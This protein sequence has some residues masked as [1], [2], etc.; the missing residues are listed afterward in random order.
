MVT[1]VGDGVALV[2]ALVAPVGG[3]DADGVEHVGAFVAPV[4][5][6]D[7]TFGE[8]VAPVGDAVAE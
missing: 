7:A 1:G 2:G 8:I 4:G 3:F 5:G 6:F